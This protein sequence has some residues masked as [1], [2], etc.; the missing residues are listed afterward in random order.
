MRRWNYR[1]TL[2]WNKWLQMWWYPCR[3]LP[4]PSTLRSFLILFLH[5]HKQFARFSCSILP[6]SWLKTLTA[7][8]ARQS[9]PINALGFSKHLAAY[10]RHWSSACLPKWGQSHD[11]ASWRLMKHSGTVDWL[12]KSF[13]LHC[14]WQQSWRYHLIASDRLDNGW[15]LQVNGLDNSLQLDHIWLL[16]EWGSQR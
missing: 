9:T 12:G 6:S 3:Y 16:M 10:L 2:C 1:R 5:T 14:P 8:F 4:M 15:K 13:L 7:Q 11:T